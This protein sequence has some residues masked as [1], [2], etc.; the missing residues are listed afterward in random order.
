MKSSGTYEGEK[1]EF[2]VKKTY[3][4][5]AKEN[6]TLTQDISVLLEEVDSI[7]QK[8]GWLKVSWIISTVLFIALVGLSYIAYAEISSSSEEKMKA[9]ESIEKFENMEA[10]KNSLQTQ[11]DASEA[12]VG[13]LQRQ[14]EQTSTNRDAAVERKQGLERELGQM[15]VEL[16]ELKDQVN[17]QKTRITN[18]EQS[19]K[20]LEQK[21]ST[22]KQRADEAEALVEEWEEFYD[23]GNFN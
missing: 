2:E 19:N 14:I 20:T 1:D 12:E 22:E 21:V 10:E 11:L 7:S 4:E 9:Q 16:A 15:E 17:G 8:K 13:R 6:E 3:D 5:L 23:E 18:L